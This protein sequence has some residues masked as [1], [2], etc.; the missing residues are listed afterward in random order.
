MVQT[1][2]PKIIKNLHSLVQDIRCQD[3]LQPTT[4][5]Y[6]TTIPCEK[7]CL[8]TCPQNTIYNCTNPLPANSN[9]G[10]AQSAIG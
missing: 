3:K 8:S 9:Y 10:S 5:M 2:S 7:K 4:P 6:Q 1:Q